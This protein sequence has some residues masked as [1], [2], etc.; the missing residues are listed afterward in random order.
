MKTTLV[1]NT[2]TIT[3]KA[4]G[5]KPERNRFISSATIEVGTIEPLT[6]NADRIKLLDKIYEATNL[7]TGWYWVKIDEVIPA[8]R[9][10]TSLS[11]G[12]EIE[13]N[14]FK[15]RC[16]DFGWTNIDAV[17]NVELEYNEVEILAALVKKYMKE[18]ESA[19]QG[20]TEF[21]DLLLKLQMKGL[22]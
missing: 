9:T 12:D 2:V 6:T 13:I 17:V 22:C 15:Y 21:G 11:V 7:Q 3:W 5:N 10:H 18:N 4:F 8:N 19:L 14:G 16:D 1:K 20:T